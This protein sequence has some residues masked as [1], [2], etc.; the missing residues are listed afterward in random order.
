MVYFRLLLLLVF[1]LSTVQEYKQVSCFLARLMVYQEWPFLCGWSS[2]YTLSSRNFHLFWHWTQA[3]NGKWK[4]TIGF[5]F[6]FLVFHSWQN[7]SSSKSSWKDLLSD[8]SR[9]VHLRMDNYR[10]RDLKFICLTVGWIGLLL[11]TTTFPLVLKKKLKFQ[12]VVRRNTF[13]FH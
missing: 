13:D 2:N 11:G 3:W 4:P 1:F 9:I 8:E 7:Y 12:L 10:G 5:K 6:Y